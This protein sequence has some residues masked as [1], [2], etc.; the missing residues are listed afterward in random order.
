[1]MEVKPKQERVRA[2]ECLYRLYRPGDETALNEMFNEVFRTDRTLEA[3]RWKYID[4]PAG[5]GCIA[6]GCLPEGAMVA[7]YGGYPLWLVRN[8]NGKKTRQLAFHA[9]DVL[10]RPE[11][12]AIGIGKSSMLVRTTRVFQE[13][14]A[15]QDIP[16]YFGFN[17]DVARKF[18][19][20]FQNYRD[21]G[22]VGYWRMEAARLERQTFLERTLSRW[23][24]WEVTPGLAEANAMDAFFQEVCDQYGWMIE[25]GWQYLDW[26]YRTRP[27]REYLTL[28]LKKRGKVMGWGVFFRQGEVLQWGDA[29]FSRAVSHKQIQ[30]LLQ[31][32]VDTCQGSVSR[33]EAWFSPYPGW[34]SERMRNT[35]FVAIAE[36]H[37][38]SLQMIPVKEQNVEQ[39]VND[40]FYYTWGDSDLF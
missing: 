36:P 31:Q 15:R 1:M 22:A 3:W 12:R 2:A 18:G 20:M 16:F 23:Q 5:Q 25:R 35:G 14:L 21:G 37:D 6:L 39:Y 38:L 27:D 26:R 29:L 11:A 30:R 19:Q 8:D 24:G 13:D 17:T 33:V 28:T 10:T 7:H 4:N 32:A 40:G 34:W 9:G